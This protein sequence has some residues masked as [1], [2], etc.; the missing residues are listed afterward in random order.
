MLIQDVLNCPELSQLISTFSGVGTMLVSYTLFLYLSIFP[1]YGQGAKNPS[2][3]K[4]WLHNHNPTSKFR[5]PLILR[6][7]F[8]YFGYLRITSSTRPSH[9]PDLECSLKDP[10]PTAHCLFQNMRHNGAVST[11]TCV[12]FLLCSCLFSRFGVGI[13]VCLLLVSWFGLGFRRNGVDLR[14]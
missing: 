1:C 6:L 2:A 11:E 14:G 5:L 9:C 3:D 13:W 10:L 4:V 8:I 12:C 7:H